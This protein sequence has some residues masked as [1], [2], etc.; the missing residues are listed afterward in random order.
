[1]LWNRLEKKISCIPFRETLVILHLHSQHYLNR[2]ENKVK[3]NRIQC[4]K[5]K[6]WP[7]IW[8]TLPLI[9][10][11][12]MS[13]LPETYRPCIHKH[14]LTNLVKHTVFYKLQSMLLRG[15]VRVNQFKYYL[16]CSER[17]YVSTVLP[18][19]KQSKTLT[20]DFRDPSYMKKLQCICWK[21]VWRY[22]SHRN[23][24]HNLILYFS[25]PLWTPLNERYYHE[26]TITNLSK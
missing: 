25:F 26:L 20:N 11:S 14:T 9:T 3:R 17:K 10:D 4:M 18:Q 2:D 5:L 23:V 16:L 7:Q 8:L 12:L 15:I 21:L 13:P 22:C 6:I 1:M 19:R 24:L